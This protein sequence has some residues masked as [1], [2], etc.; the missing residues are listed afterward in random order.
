M[1]VTLPLFIVNFRDFFV[2]RMLGSLWLGSPAR[3]LGFRAL[4]H[5]GVPEIGR[6]RKPNPRA[7]YSRAEVVFEYR[8]TSLSR[9]FFAS[10]VTGQPTIQSLRAACLPYLTPVFPLASESAGGA[11]REMD[12]GF[13]VPPYDDGQPSRCAAGAISTK[14]T[15][16]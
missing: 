2:L 5:A 11:A 12:G 8:Y 3:G 14:R 7:G 15:K 4:P 9:I 13:R 16:L 6:T 1:T 10:F